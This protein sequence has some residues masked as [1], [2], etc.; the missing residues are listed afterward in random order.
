MNNLV[1]R[2]LSPGFGGGA[3]NPGKS[4]LGT[5]TEVDQ[6]SDREKLPFTSEVLKNKYTA[7]DIDKIVDEERRDERRRWDEVKYLV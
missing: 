2:A 5:R 6:L 7:K 4:A 3:Q 1:P